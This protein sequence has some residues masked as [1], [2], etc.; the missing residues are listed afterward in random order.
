MQQFRFSQLALV[1]AMATLTTG[2]FGLLATVAAQN[3]AAYNPA[4]PPHRWP[5]P[6]DPGPRGRLPGAG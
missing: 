5:I 4:S 6:V 2:L 3:V 1:A